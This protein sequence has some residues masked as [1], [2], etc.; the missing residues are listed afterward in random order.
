MGTRTPG[1][2][3]TVDHTDPGIDAGVMFLGREG[4]NAV[5]V[6]GG[7]RKQCSACGAEVPGEAV[8]CTRCGKSQRAA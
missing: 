5:T 6:G 3:E 8:A 4:K 2:G 1:G 7:D